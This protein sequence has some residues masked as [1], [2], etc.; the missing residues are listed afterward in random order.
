MQT[1]DQVK[2]LVRQKY[3]A[4]LP[5]DKTTNQ[6]SCCGAGGT[7]QVYNIMADEL[8]SIRGYHPD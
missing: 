5:W 8:R 7:Q 2:E 3:S 6:G 1:Q 4:K